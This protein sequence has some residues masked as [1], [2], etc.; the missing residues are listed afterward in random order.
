[1]K[2]PA[3]CETWTYWWIVKWSGPQPLASIWVWSWDPLRFVRRHPPHDLS[4]ARGQNS[5]QGKTPKPASAAPSRQ[6]QRSDQGRK[7]VISERIVTGRAP[8]P[9]F[10]TV[11]SNPTL[12]A[13]LTATVHSLR[14]FAGN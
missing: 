14:N 2:A 6:Q 3:E 7:P 9:A 8:N 11:G 4:P 13:S 10:R 1:M 12:S 5:R